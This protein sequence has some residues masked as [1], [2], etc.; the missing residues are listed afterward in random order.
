MRDRPSASDLLAWAL[1]GLG[2]GVVAGILAAHW[3][4]P[5]DRRRVRRSLDRLTGADRTPAPL[6]AADA[7]RQA[8]AAVRQDDALRGLELRFLAV[9]PG[10]IELHGWVP[11][12]LLRARAARVVAAQDGIE[13]VVNCLLVHGEDD[14]GLRPLDATDQPA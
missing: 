10:V 12:R 6:K 9:G 1:L 11:T 14:L 3:L 13:S 7:I 2:T 8:R 4:G 5:V